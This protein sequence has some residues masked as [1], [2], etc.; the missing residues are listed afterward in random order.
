[1]AKWM[2]DKALQRIIDSVGRLASARSQPESMADYP[3][4]QA[5]CG[6]ELLYCLVVL[7]WL[8]VCLPLQ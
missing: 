8:P 7:C 6:K 3:G 5:A 1:M 4:R 2:P